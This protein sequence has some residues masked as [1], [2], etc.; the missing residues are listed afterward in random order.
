MLFCQMKEIAYVYAERLDR[1]Q[2]LEQIT[3]PSE[4]SNSGALA[5]F[6]W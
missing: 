5:L 4:M 6:A 3:S 2:A 1:N